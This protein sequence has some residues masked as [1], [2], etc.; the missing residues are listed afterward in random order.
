VNSTIAVLSTA[1]EDGELLGRITLPPLVASVVGVVVAKHSTDVPMTGS[2][3]DLT[4]LFA[5][6]VG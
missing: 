5:G 4:N 2:R 3:N 1:I 6:I